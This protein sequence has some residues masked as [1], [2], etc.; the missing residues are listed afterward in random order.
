MADQTWGGWEMQ[1]KVH[2]GAGKPS[3]LWGRP[4]GT[5]R[6]GGLAR[7]QQVLLLGWR[8]LEWHQITKDLEASASPSVTPC[9]WTIPNASK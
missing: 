4:V 9:R 2:K 1:G 5:C 6:E 7:Q 8:L 3:R